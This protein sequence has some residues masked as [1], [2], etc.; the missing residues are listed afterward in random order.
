MKLQPSNMWHYFTKHSKYYEYNNDNDDD[1]DV[2]VM[3]Q[4]YLNKNGCH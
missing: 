2:Q 1:D 3:Q 4:S